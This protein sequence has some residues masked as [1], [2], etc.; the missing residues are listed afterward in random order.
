MEIH[1]L[2]RSDHKRIIM[3]ALLLLS[4]LVLGYLLYAIVKPEKF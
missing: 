3:T 2:V 4:L 1:R